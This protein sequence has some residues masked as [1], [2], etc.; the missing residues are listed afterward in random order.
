MVHFLRQNISVF[1]F[2]MFLVLAVS[3]S[4]FVFPRQILYMVGRG[5]LRPDLSKVR[6]DIPKSFKKLLLDCIKFSRDERPLFP[7]VCCEFYLITVIEGRH[8]ATYNKEL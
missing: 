1:Q 4:C 8:W 5:Y 2:R 6:S 3:L 7:Q